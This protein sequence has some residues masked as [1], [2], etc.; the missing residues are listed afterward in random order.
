MAITNIREDFVGHL[1]D[2]SMFIGLD[3]FAETFS[4]RKNSCALDYSA[5]PSSEHSHAHSRAPANIPEKNVG[6]GN[7]P[8]VVTSGQSYQEGRSTEVQSPTLDRIVLGYEITIN[9]L[10]D[11]GNHVQMDCTG[12]AAMNNSTEATPP[13]SRDE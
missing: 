9:D 8:N 1:S 5:A 4:S 12:D 7:R 10:S 3:R 6:S 11:G 2:L 13:E